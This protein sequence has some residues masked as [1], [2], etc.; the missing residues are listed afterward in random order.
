MAPWAQG[1]EGGE[2]APKHAGPVGLDEG[3]AVDLCVVR[4]H[5]AL[6]SLRLGVGAGATPGRKA[7]VRVAKHVS[8]DDLSLAVRRE[9][10]ATY[11]LSP[12]GFS[13][14]TRDGL[15]G[16][17][18]VEDDEGAEGGAAA[19]ASAA[20]GEDENQ[21]EMDMIERR[22]G[23]ARSLEAE[24]PRSQCADRDACKRLRTDCKKVG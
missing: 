11:G 2:N 13:S 14:V 4:V 17:L 6:V 7:S 16:G 18:G 1:G 21:E 8:R 10:A 24:R 3:L 20:A 23:N 19:G 9:K 15:L 22:A 5:E 12:S